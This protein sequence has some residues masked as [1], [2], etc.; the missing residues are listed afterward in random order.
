MSALVVSSRFDQIAEEAISEAASDR[1]AGEGKEGGSQKK[2][3]VRSLV[4]QDR[5][6]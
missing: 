4:C 2:G 1:G 3:L 6:R 5:G